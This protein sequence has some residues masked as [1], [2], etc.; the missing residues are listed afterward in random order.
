M[1]DFLAK[2]QETARIVAQ[3]AAATAKAV[4][5]AANAAALV[6]ARE[7]AVYNSKMAILETKMEIMERQQCS[8]ESEINRKLE[9]LD[10]KFDKI[11]AK[12]EEIVTGRPTWA[13]LCII[14]LLSC[15]VVGLTTYVVGHL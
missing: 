15:L 3:T 11:Y 5:E 13:I 1:E 6:V 9:N 14:T 7:S 4:S 2:E 12:L 10:P 8:F